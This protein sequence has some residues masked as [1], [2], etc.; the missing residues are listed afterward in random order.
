MA[1]KIDSG[2]AGAS[3]A[4]GHPGARLWIASA[5]AAN[6]E[7]ASIS[8]GSPTAFDREIGS[9]RLTPSNNATRKSA[10][11]SAAQ[12]DF[13]VRGLPR[14]RRPTVGGGGEGGRREVWLMKSGNASD[15]LPGS[16][17]LARKVMGSAGT[18]H[19]PDEKAISRALRVRAAARAAM[20]LRSEPE[21]AAVADVF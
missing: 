13:E 6:I 16:P 3:S 11:T 14:G 4:T 17:W 7:I 1:R 21:E 5:I 2:V 10:G 15:W 20:P 9:S 18:S 19:F 8:G 12:G